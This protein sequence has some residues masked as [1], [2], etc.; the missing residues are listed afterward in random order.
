MRAALAG[1]IFFS[2]AAT[3]YA[4]TSSIQLPRQDASLTLGWSGS[5]Y[6]R[7]EPYDNRWHQSLL[8]GA[9]YGRYWTAHAKTEVEAAWFSPV[10]FTAYEVQTVSGGTTYFRTDYR[11]QDAR[12]SFAQLYQ[13]GENQWV[14]PYAGLGVNL[15]YRRQ[16]EDRAPQVV[17]VNGSGRTIDTVLVPGESENESSVRAHPFAKVGFKMYASDRAFF[18]SEWK[19][20][21]GSGLQHVLW[22]TGVGFDF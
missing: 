10:D 7:V 12:L 16:V 6:P 2:V 5:R 4:Q 11:F 13:F 9:E 3:A 19:F 17:P 15:D 20:G 1:L 18:I 14:H 22:K 21:F 8:A